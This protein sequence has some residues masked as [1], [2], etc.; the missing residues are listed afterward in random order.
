MGSIRKVFKKARKIVSKPISKI[1]KGIAKGIAKVGKSIL[2]GVAKLNKKMGPLGMI[3]MSIA[4]PWALNGLSNIVGQGAVGAFGPQIPSGLMS[5]QNVFLRSIGNVGNTIRM[6]YNGV[7]GAIGKVKQG[8]KGITRS[9]TE[10]FSKMSGG[11]GKGLWSKISNGAKRLFT[12]ARNTIKK[13]TPKFRQGTSGSVDVYGLRGNVHGEGLIKTSMKSADAASMLQSGAIDAS[14]ISGQSL[15]SAEGWFTQ[16][17]SPNADKI[18]TETLNST[19]DDAIGNSLDTNGSRWINDL[20]TNG[21]A[22]S[23]YANKW[24]AYDSV[25]KSGAW[26]TTADGTYLNLAET[27]DYTL[28]AGG[29]GTDKYTFNGKKS[30]NTKVSNVN[31]TTNKIGEKLKK[32]VVKKAFKFAKDFLNPTDIPTI[33]PITTAGAEFAKGESG[34]LTSSSSQ[35]GATGSSSYA[36]VF[37]TAA[38]QQL[39]GYHRNMNYQGDMDYYGQ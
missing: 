1:T 38:W 10:G 6:G 26:N 11:K 9:I 18:I 16:A 24:D 3:A 13:Y 34:A 37:G 8:I 14:Q 7:T 15:G 35:A 28:G 23:R 25:K 30:F 17:G 27:G 32:K 36:D 22:N 33:E 5:S 19:F 12:N 31:G 2:K 20:Y 4:M 29:G 21:T 39:K